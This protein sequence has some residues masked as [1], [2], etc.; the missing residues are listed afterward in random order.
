[1]VIFRLFTSPSEEVKVRDLN[2]VDSELLPMD[3]MQEIA[4]YA[5]F[6]TSKILSSVS[7][8]IRNVISIQNK[9]RRNFVKGMAFGKEEWL[10]FY[11]LDIGYEPMLPRDIIEIIN[12]PCYMDPSRSL[13]DTHILTIIPRGISVKK[14]GKPAKKYFPTR[15]GFRFTE[16]SVVDALKTPND[17]S[18]W[19]LMSKDVLNGSRN[20]SFKTQQKMVAEL[21]QNANVHCEVPTALEAAVSILTHQVRLGERLFSDNPETYTRCLDMYEGYQ[22]IVGGFAPSGLIVTEISN[23][24]DSDDDGV[25]VLRKFRPMAIG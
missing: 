19:V 15:I 4:K 7:K 3:V 6:D 22:V 11:D 14:F 12:S 17:K 25:A 23:Y 5:D 2:A 9:E 8:G 20:K 10:K 1:M 16:E 18:Y 21:S 24:A 13:R